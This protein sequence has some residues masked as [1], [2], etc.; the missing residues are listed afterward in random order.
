MPLQMATITINIDPMLHLGP[1]MI[2]WHGLMIGVGIVFGA[3]LARRFSDEIGLDRDRLFDLIGILV[4]AG[5]VGSR[6]LYLILNEPSALIDP[7]RWLG[8]RGFAF[9]GALILGPLAAALYIRRAHLSLRYLDALA[10]GFP[11]GMAVGRIGDVISGEH[12][13]PATTLPW[14]FR[15]LNPH[16]EVPSSHFAYHQGGFYEIILALAMLAVLW[17][18]R[19]RFR[20]PTSLLWTTVAVYSAGRF[21]MFFYRSDTTGFAAGLN[22]AQVTSLALF[23]V[24]LLG[25]WWARRS[26]WAGEART[27]PG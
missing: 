14:G 7:S 22:V 13:G 20:R 5:I 12:Y 8:N 16:A 2:A 18:L 27:V 11:L 23:A 21:V 17:P 9:F 15:Y 24:A 1:V 4:L 19:D 6:L 25:L 26:Q 10:A 3:L